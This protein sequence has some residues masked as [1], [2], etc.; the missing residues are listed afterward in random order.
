MHVQ[1]FW[2]KNMAMELLSVGYY[3]ASALVLQI[4]VH[5]SFK[6]KKMNL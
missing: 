1:K 3:F 6:K 2:I 4:L 5:L